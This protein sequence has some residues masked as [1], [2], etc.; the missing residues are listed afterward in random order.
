[1]T[2]A[3]L[4][5]AWRNGNDWALARLIDQ[6]R[7][8]LY[9]YLLKHTGQA[10]DAEDLFQDTWVKV[11]GV[12]PRYEE[13]DQFKS[14]LF[15]VASRLA[16]D[17]SRVR[18]RRLNLMEEEGEQGWEERIPAHLDACPEWHLASG[19][20]EE[21]LREAIDHLPEP[22]RVVVLLRLEAGMT[23]QEIADVQGAPVGTVLPRMHRAVKAI[24]R[25]FSVRGHHE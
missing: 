18:Q 15:T 4:I 2:D 19:R 5:Q 6:W 10:A 14:L 9:G 24:R 25:Y 11:L 22:Q 13:R 8:P 20:R 16:I 3:E 1:M 21:L 23:F 12:L 17:H 7:R